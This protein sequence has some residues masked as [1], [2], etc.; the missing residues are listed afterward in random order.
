[1]FG[2][3]ALRAFSPGVHCSARMWPAGGLIELYT[4][5]VAGCPGLGTTVRGPPRT[6]PLPAMTGAARA[7]STVAE[8]SSFHKRFI[9]P[10]MGT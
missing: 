3:M 6:A 7:S 8:I 1:M 4:R 2:P 10:P 9:Y 5:G